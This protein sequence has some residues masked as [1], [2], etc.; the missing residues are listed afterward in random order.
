MM[1]GSST[2]MKTRMAKY[3]QEL[4]QLRG[5]SNAPVAPATPIPTDTPLRVQVVTEH[6][7]PIAGALVT[8]VGQVGEERKLQHV[9]FTDKNGSVEPLTLSVKTDVAYEITVSAP[10]FYRKTDS[11]LKA[12]G[13]SVERV[14]VLQSLPEYV[15][16]W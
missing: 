16:E 11:G 10:G 15:E 12:D 13:S 9:R 7:T 1:N 4:M 8:V 5:R 3:E 2:D 14:I 6:G